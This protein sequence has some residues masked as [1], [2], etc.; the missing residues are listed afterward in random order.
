MRRICA[1]VKVCLD[2]CEFPRWKILSLQC[3]W[4]LPLCPVSSSVHRLK[5]LVEDK[6]ILSNQSSSLKW[7]QSVLGIT[8]LSHVFSSIWISLNARAEGSS[9]LAAHSCSGCWKEKS[10]LS[11]RG[12]TCHKLHLFE[13]SAVGAA[14]SLFEA[15]QTPLLTH[16]T[17]IYA[18][19]VQLG[20]KEGR[21]TCRLFDH[22]RGVRICL[23]LV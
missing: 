5:S 2:F 14:F 13:S 21:E 23:S 9:G 15:W 11:D 4:R 18:T 1:K 19:T 17:Y 3:L 20:Y 8:V 16:I 7:T 6:A 22:R 10:G 12:K